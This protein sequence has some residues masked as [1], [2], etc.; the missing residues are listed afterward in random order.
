MLLLADGLL[1]SV[2]DLVCVTR[3][4]SPCPTGTGVLLGVAPCDPT[5]AEQLWTPAAVTFYDYAFT[6]AAG[7]AGTADAC[8]VPGPAVGAGGLPLAPILLNWA[9]LKAWPGGARAALHAALTRLA[10]FRTSLLAQADALYTLWLGQYVA[11]GRADAGLP[12]HLCRT[13]GHRGS[14]AVTD[15]LLE[16]EGPVL[17][18]TPVHL[19]SLDATLQ[20]L[21]ASGTAADAATAAAAYAVASTRHLKARAAAVAGGLA[22]L[23]ERLRALLMG[24][25][26]KALTRAAEHLGAVARRMHVRLMEA[27]N[28]LQA[29]REAARDSALRTLV[30][31]VCVARSVVRASMVTPSSRLQKASGPYCV[32]RSRNPIEV[33][34][35]SISCGL[36]AVGHWHMP[37]LQC[38]H[39]PVWYRVL[40]GEVSVSGGLL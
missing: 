20:K 34:E 30:R 7:P 13:T 29:Q 21:L 15:G 14:C 38:G 23:D 24:T 35:T 6:A 3:S 8:A 37:T 19:Q 32:S 36:W 27:W 22:V 1:L 2:N 16:A 9:Q 28:K 10:N 39:V 40:E 31:N 12:Q 5:A 26:E 33:V 17:P 18:V 11:G 4:P 25:F